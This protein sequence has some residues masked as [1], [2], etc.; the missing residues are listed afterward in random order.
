MWISAIVHD[1]VGDVI[2]YALEAN[3]DKSRNFIWFNSYIELL[4]ESVKFSEVHKSNNLS[5]YDDD[6][7]KVCLDLQIKRIL[8]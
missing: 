6:D 5:S 7:E 3:D 8:L 4:E 2:E 1:Y